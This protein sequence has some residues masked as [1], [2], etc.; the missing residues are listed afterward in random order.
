MVWYFTE[1]LTHRRNETPESDK[2]LFTK[3]FVEIE[4]MPPVTFYHQPSTR[5]W[6][7]EI[8][9]ENGENY[10]V[11]CRETDYLAAAKQEIPD[12]WWKYTRKSDQLSKY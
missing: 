9:V 6:W 1:A 7:M 12:V 3:Y 8:A 11:A 2:S 10:I 5:R 4:Q